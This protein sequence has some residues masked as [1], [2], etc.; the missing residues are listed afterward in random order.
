MNYRHIYHAG[1]FADIFKH[2]IARLITKQML[3]KDRNFVVVD[4]FAGCGLYPLS[5]HESLKTLEYI[6]GI[7]AFMQTSFHSDTLREFQNSLQPDWVKKIYKGSPLQLQNLL[8]AGDRLIANEL[9]PEDYKILHRNLSHYANALCQHMDAYTCIKSTIPP[10]E[11]RGFILVD[12]P[13]EKKNEFELL[14]KNI[15]LWKEK[16]P[17][18]V[19]A[20]WYPIKA[21]DMSLN[22]KDAVKTEL[23]HRSFCFECLRYPREQE[24]SF[25]GCGML[26]LNT[27]F[28]IPESVQ[29]LKA[30][31]ET[32]LNVSIAITSL[33]TE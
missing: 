13:F 22:L 28:T 8:R 16:F 18:G 15:K 19:Y 20:I 4:A 27:P 26:V 21:H 33:T 2:L 5:S 29:E 23:I 32:C 17:Q 30:E 10:Q 9:H 3:K 24:N 25:N 14:I 7:E 6:D 1:N 31:L 11:R 12:P